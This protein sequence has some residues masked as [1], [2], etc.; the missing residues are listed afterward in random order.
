MS[1]A[2][3]AI[4]HPR[5]I[6]SFV[7][8][9]GRMTVAQKRALETGLPRWGLS[10]ENG[11]LDAQ[12]AFGRDAPRILEI[13]FGMGASLAEQAARHPERDYLGIEVHPPGVGT[14]L[15]TLD[16]R[17]LTNVRVFM[18]DAIEVLERCI[19]DAWLDGVQLFFPDPWPK[20][21]HHKRRIV[22]PAFAQRIRHKLKPG[23]LFHLATD[24]APYAEHMLAVLD[25]ADGF[26]NTAGAGQC[27][28]RP[29]ERPHTKFEQRGERLGHEVF[30]LIYERCA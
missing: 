17:Q 14:L 4:A 23:G 11:R 6:R 27:S 7:V 3:E 25:A 2:N 21:R 24:W 28:P 12:A 20:A 19:P 10:V 22:Q 18:H 30:D 15:A 9:A 16:A 5:S 13:G 8:R 29:A 26:R 1:E